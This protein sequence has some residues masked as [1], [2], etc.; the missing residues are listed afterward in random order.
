MPEIRQKQKRMQQTESLA[1]NKPKFSE[2]DPSNTKI[3][4][5]GHQ[6]SNHR[7]VSKQ[8]SNLKSLEG[9]YQTEIIEMQSELFTDEGAVSIQ[10][11]Q[12]NV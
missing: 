1:F 9:H 4:L 5:K 12:A 3:S 11:V 8:C 10:R 6:I 7:G 2:Q